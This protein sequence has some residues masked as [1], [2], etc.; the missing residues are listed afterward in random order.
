ME[1][2][3]ISVTL[4]KASNPHGANLAHNNRDFIAR[5]IRRDQMQNNIFFKQQDVREAYSE[6]FGAAIVDYNA[7]QKQP[8][9]RIKD[10]Y[11]HIA[12]GKREEP[13]YE[14]IVQLGDCKDTPC[15][16]PRAEIAKKILA[17]YAA[18]F[19]ERNKNL[20]VFNSVMHLDEASPHLHIDFVPFYTEGRQRGLSK[21]V[22]MRAALKEMG[23]TA[24]NSG[25][26]QLVIWEERERKTLEQLL[27]QHECQREDKQA[28]HHHLTVEEYKSWQDAKR[29]SAVFR[30]KQRVEPE[31]IRDALRMKQQ[32]AQLTSINAA[33]KEQMYSPYKSFFYADDDKRAFVQAA[34]DREKIPYR[35]TENGFEAQE[36]YV[37]AIRRIEAQ[38]KKQ[39]TSRRDKLR[40]DID[41]LLMMSKDFDQLL[42]RLCDAHYEIRL[43][44]YIA[45]RPADGKNYIR[46]K[47]LGSAYSE[48]VLRN[49]LEIKAA[50]EQNLVRMIQAARD[51]HAPNLRVLEMMRRYTIL[52]SDGHFPVRKKNP[53]G[54]LSWQ[55]DAELDRLT[56]LN[57]KINQGATLD[58]MRRDAEK[59]QQKVNELTERLEELDCYVRHHEDLVECAQIVFYDKQS[60]RFTPEEAR[61]LLRKESYLN[62]GNWRESEQ[63]I[64]KAKSYRQNVTDNL[65]Q[66]EAELREAVGYL[67]TAE[68]VL[69]GSFLQVLERQED[70]RRKA[71]SGAVPNGQTDA[72]A[73]QEPPR[74]SSRRK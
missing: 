36:C 6:L 3:S 43:G 31:D 10:Y 32:I 7:K 61:E 70:Q 73:P 27:R 17:E 38:Y 50:Y 21:G 57:A 69:G 48:D 24:K 74:M 40:D 56:A 63:R 67:T 65:R 44:K 39:P 13:F 19:Q 41:R 4:G 1:R 12:S 51:M 47:S 54:I 23:I 5:N 35:E 16:S 66:A 58:S 30:E 15:G 2:F 33:M 28:H 68:Q 42:Q 29:N 53:K 25:V 34:L 20:H 9:R 60:A 62:A 59:K 49:R 26:N 55:N 8:C 11:S 71:E 72:D 46:L 52:F 64:E 22:S 45:V 14:V 37:D 18:K